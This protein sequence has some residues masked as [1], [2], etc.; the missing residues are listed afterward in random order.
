VIIDLFP[1]NIYKGSLKPSD[2]QD[3]E[4]YLFLMKKFSESES[5]VW[6]GETGKTTG[7]KGLKLHHN[8]QFDWLFDGLSEHII[9]YW[10]KLNY[11][12][13]QVTLR[14]SWANLH[15]STDTTAEHSHSD[16]HPGNTHIS[17]VYYLRK[18]F[19]DGHIHICDP[20]DYVK[21]L[22]P[23]KYMYGI[24]TISQEVECQQYD[25]I[26]FPSWV[27]HRVPTYTLNQERIA[28]SFNYIGYEEI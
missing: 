21:R 6:S 23:N 12:D 3:T 22:T 4:T 7:N 9:S 24:E 25:F 15:Y 16:G 19:Q 13:F 14:D 18:P 1:L 8:S 20:M 2:K 11:A 27:R 26:L 17:G 5:G 28:I 10:N